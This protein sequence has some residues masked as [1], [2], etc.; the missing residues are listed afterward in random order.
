MSIIKEQY[1]KK[2][3]T[4]GDI[5][6]YGKKNL[7]IRMDKKEKLI[8]NLND[9]RANK[10]LILKKLWRWRIIKNRFRI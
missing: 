4:L 8:Q 10:E 9:I 3:K 7:K 6:L 1:D 5:F 2:T